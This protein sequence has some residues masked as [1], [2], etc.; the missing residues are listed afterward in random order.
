MILKR[1]IE[2]IASFTF[3]IVS[4]MTGCI[5][6][7][8]DAAQPTSGSTWQAPSTPQVVLKN[9]ETGLADLTGANYERSIGDNFKFEPLLDDAQNPTLFG[10]YDDWTADVEKEVLQIILSP[11]TVAIASFTI[12]QQILDTTT[13]AEFKVSYTLNLTRGTAET[14]AGRA[15]FDMENINGSW[16]LV[17]WRDEEQEPGSATWGF[18]RG[19]SRPRQ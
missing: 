10:Q 17:L 8:R 1:N 16:Q 18:L 7:T 2:L 3:V 6:E 13:R 9:L 15:Q 11:A 14:F 4:G 5:F 19:V 12:D